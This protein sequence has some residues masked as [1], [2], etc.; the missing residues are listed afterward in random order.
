MFPLMPSFASVDRE[1][2]PP[3]EVNTSVSDMS[4]HEKISIAAVDAAASAR[5]AALVTRQ[6]LAGL[7]SYLRE[8]RRA[9][10]DKKVEAAAARTRPRRGSDV[11]FVDSGTRGHWTSSIRWQGAVEEGIDAY[12]NPTLV[13]QVHWSE[14]TRKDCRFDSAFEVFMDH[15]VSFITEQPPRLNEF[16]ELLNLDVAGERDN[17]LDLCQTMDRLTSVVNRKVFE[18]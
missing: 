6:K 8:Q 1:N 3:P 9:A 2:V 18:L 14:R 15:D 7:E 5:R 12:I 16:G 17:N 13:E 11:I 10:E 4:P